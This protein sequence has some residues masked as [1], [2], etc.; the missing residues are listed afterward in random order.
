MKDTYFYIPAVKQDPAGNVYTPDKPTT[1]DQVER[2]T[3]PR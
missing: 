2:L 1:L 3:F